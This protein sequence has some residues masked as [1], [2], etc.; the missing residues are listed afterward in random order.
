MMT[1]ACCAGCPVKVTVAVC[2]RAVAVTVAGVEVSAGTG[3]R[4]VTDGPVVPESVPGP[5]S[6]QIPSFAKSTG[7]GVISTGP[8]IVCE[9]VGERVNVGCGSLFE[10]AARRTE[11]TANI[12]VRIDF[13]RVVVFQG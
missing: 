5:A 9:P 8:E 4:E 2:P 11:A 13:S 7:L 12:R 1:L 10:Q 6:D 3:G